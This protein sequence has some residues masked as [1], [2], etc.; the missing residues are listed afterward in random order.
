L[1]A[2]RESVDSSK[3]N[4]SVRVGVYRAFVSQAVPRFNAIHSNPAGVRY[5]WPLFLKDRGG[6]DE[7]WSTLK[8]WIFSGLSKM[9]VL[10]CRH[11][12]KLT[13]PNSLFYIPLEFRF[14]GK[15]LVEDESTESNHLSFAY[16]ADI[17][18]ILPELQKMGVKV[19]SFLDF[20]SELRS[21]VTRQGISFLREQ[22]GRWH[23]QVAGLFLNSHVR[24][25]QREDIPLIPLRDG[26]WVTSSER[27]I[28]LEE[29]TDRAAVP[30]GLDINL[31]DAE[32]CRDPIRKNFFRW[33]GIKNCD[34]AEVCKLIMQRYNPFR[35][36]P[37]SQSSQDL[38][39]LFQVPW[40][41]YKESLGNLHLLAAPPHYGFR[42]K[43]FYIEYPRRSSILS[44]YAMNSASNFALLDPYYLNAVRNL[45]K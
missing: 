20:I 36:L 3:W 45:G 13:T 35:P 21:L 44:K 42:A 16:D 8:G 18:Q 26:R 28:F 39:Y 29:D 30:D 2:N 27:H 12:T 24:A 15:P 22:P 37:L 38:I 14:E 32:A 33:L 4:D 25:S 19:L 10:E 1:V 34:Q 43:R 17:N 23:S 5:S 11:N 40:D 31:V 6:T 7:F 9:D 41:V